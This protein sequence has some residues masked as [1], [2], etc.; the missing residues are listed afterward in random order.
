MPRKNHG[1]NFR[2]DFNQV[3]L[4][5]ISFGAVFMQCCVHGVGSALHLAS[6]YIKQRC[7]AFTGCQLLG[8]LDQGVRCA[9]R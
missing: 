7:G 2:N 3:N 9:Q 1:A 6:D 8:V 4:I 5:V